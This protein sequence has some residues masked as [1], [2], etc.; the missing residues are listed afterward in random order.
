MSLRI[1]HNIAALNGNR[2]LNKNDSALSKSLERLSSG[3]RINRA[4][5]DAAGLII[6]EQ[7]RGQ[8]A[9]IEQ[10][11]RN[12]EA[13]VSM[14]QTAE[15][16]LDEVNN[17]LTKARQLALH[18]AN[19]AVND[20]NQLQ[21]DQTELDNIIESVDRIALQT[22]FGT[23]KLLDG[24]L[25]TFRSNSP[26]IGSSTT[27]GHYAQGLAQ[28]T[29]QRGYHS[30]LI[31][32][33]ATQG[34]LFLS[35]GGADI[36][37]GGTLLAMSGTEQFQKA[38]TVAING[39]QIS[40]TSGQTKNDLVTAL[41]TAGRALGFTAMTI[42]GGAAAA[43]YSGVGGG[44]GTGNIVLF[45]QNYGSAST[46]TLSYV[47]GASGASSMNG[48]YT[49]GQDLSGAL[50]L[51]NGVAGGVASTGSLVIA[52]SQT[53]NSLALVSVTGGADYRISLNS[54]LSIT[55]ASNQ[56]GL[57]LGVIDGMSSGATFQVGANVGQRKS[58]SIDSARASDLGR[59]ASSLYQSL[60]SMKGSALISGDTD[61]VLRV[62]DK[63]V[64]T[65]TTMRGR[66]GAFQSN[67][68]E[69]NI[70][71][72]RVAHENL[73]ASEST[74]R[75]TDFAMESANFTRNQIMVQSATAMLSQANQMPQSVLKLI[76]G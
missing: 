14:I 4:S 73:T 28:S 8:I 6:S 16:A 25:S 2:Q 21:A 11:V 26:I 48:T 10:A 35:G 51:N 67:T 30:L 34:N 54:A 56:S 20:Q 59:G 71:S 9:G 70:S 3:M 58:V 31:T 12:S 39:I 57:Y 76:Q 42:S 47:N 18:A 24:T 65:V 29:I 62:L 45:S 1:N 19:A 68:L 27:G 5:D 32:Q 22:Q 61:E 13:G 49:A 63:A 36:M 17:L 23:K 69:S 72:L 7:M 50:L 52:L 74:I 38:F 40:I 33:E 15:G 43:S 75:D 46:L 66:M 44:A 37:T 55:G 53:G 60:A 41:N 64:D